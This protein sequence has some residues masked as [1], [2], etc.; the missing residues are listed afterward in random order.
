MLPFLAYNTDADIGLQYHAHIVATVTHCSSPL[1]GI[2]AN[3]LDNDRLLCGA[4]PAH[5]DARRSRGG[6]QELLFEIA[7]CA[8]LVNRHDQI[9]ALSVY[10]EDELLGRER[11]L[12]D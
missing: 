5:A 4:A 8:G 3:L 9:E 7:C 6:L 11:E 2:H 12:A 10:H 1:L